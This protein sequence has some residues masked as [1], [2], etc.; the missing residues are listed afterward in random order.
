MEPVFAS[1]FWSNFCGLAVL[2]RYM[3]SSCICLSVCLSQVSV[4]LKRL[5]IG[6]CKQR[7][8]IAQG[9]IAGGVR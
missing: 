5:D 1:I 7:R 9:Y 8:T 2:V 6:S 3:V 4:I